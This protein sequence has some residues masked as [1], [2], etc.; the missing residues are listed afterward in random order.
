MPDLQGTYFFADFCTDW[1]RSFRM[2]GDAVTDL[3]DRT[4]NLRVGLGSLRARSISSFGVDGLGEIYVCDHEGGEVFRMVP[5][6]ANGVPNP[7]VTTTP[8]NLEVRLEGG[9]IEFE[10]DAS[11]SDNGDGSVEGLSYRWRKES[12]PS[13]DFLSSRTDSVV[14]LRLVT[15]GEYVYSLRVDDGLD[16]ASLELS[17]VVVAPS[18]QRGDANSDGVY[19]VSDPG[20]VV[21]YLFLDGLPERA[22]R[23]AMDANDDSLVNLADVIYMLNH[24]FLGRSAPPPPHP[25][26]GND[27]TA[28]DLID[29]AAEVCAP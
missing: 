8:E 23:D 28:G 21:Y 25:E 15:P 11:A 18:F 20:A 14:E 27:P 24:Q 17:I 5:G 22:C 19:D 7:R 6:H 9:F 10:L 3:Q 1:V 16:S 13:G 12:G 26:C 4:K 2:D 29:C